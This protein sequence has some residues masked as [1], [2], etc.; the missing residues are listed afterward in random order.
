[1]NSVTFPVELGG[2]GT[3]VTD[4]RDPETGLRGGGYRDRLVPALAQSVAVNAFGVTK[5]G[6]ANASAAAAAASNSSAG[7]HAS[8]AA[9]S[10]S[11]AASS[12]GDA[13][14]SKNAAALSEAAAAASAV[15]A[16]SAVAGVAT[17][18]GRSG[19]VTLSGADI[20]GAGGASQ[21]SLSSHTGNTSNPHSTTKAQVGLGNVDNTADS[22]KP[23]STAQQNAL[24]LKANLASPTFTGTPAAPTAAAG[25]NT[26]QLA[27]TA[28]VFAER[29][30]A[31]TLTNKTLNSPTL[32]TPVLGTPTSGNLSNCT[33]DGTSAVGGIN[34]PQNSRSAAYTLVLSDRGKHIFHP[35]ADTTARVFTIP[36]NASVAF[37]I[38]TVVTFVN[39]IGAGAVTIAIT[40]DT[41]RLAGAGTTGSRTLAAG[42]EAVALKV[43]A[44]E[45]LIGGVGLS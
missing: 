3:T 37:E 27:T 26:T 4:D 43:T 31:A 22:A 36:A 33:A 17:F 1:M 39:Q 16:A 20:T 38:G 42:G 40:S 13:L 45:W 5:A 32:T 12:A 7:T 19:A 11:S 30:N 2:D 14:A 21:T 24:N 9:G 35:A 25:T 23:V 6:E 44:T 28:H 29:T 34:I 10:A 41:M 8:N 15:E 18:N